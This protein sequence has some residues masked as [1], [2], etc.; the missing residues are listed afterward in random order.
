MA[1]HGAVTCA[2]DLAAAVDRMSLLEWVCD[3][4]WRARAIG[5]PR[6]LDEDARAAV[7]SAAIERGYGTTKPVEE[8]GA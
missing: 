8:N 6:V 5:E 2:E 4:Y 3:I 7:V 1:N